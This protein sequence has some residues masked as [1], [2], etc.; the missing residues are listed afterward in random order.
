MQAL[1]NQKIRVEF[2]KREGARHVASFSAKSLRPRDDRTGAH[3]GDC[4]S[5]WTVCRA[6]ETAWET[7]L[8]YRSRLLG[9][10][11][12]TCVYNT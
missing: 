11:K 8:M 2:Q 9:M 3:G 12:V 10:S 7:E 5:C 4:F 1:T 6:W